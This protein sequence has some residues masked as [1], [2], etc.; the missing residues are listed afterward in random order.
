MQDSFEERRAARVAIQEI[1]GGDT[2]YVDRAGRGPLFWQFQA[3]MLN[4]TVWGSM[5]AALGTSNNLTIDNLD[6]HT[7]TLMDVSRPAPLSD[8]R[9]RATMQFVITDT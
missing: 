1:P 9:T 6:S 3:V 5:N 2:F 4:S 8:G 7:A